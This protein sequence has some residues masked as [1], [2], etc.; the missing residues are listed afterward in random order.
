MALRPV[1][2][3]P[4]GPGAAG[5]RAQRRG[6]HSE[7]RGL[8]ARGH[9]A[10]APFGAMAPFGGS[11]FGGSDP[12]QEFSQGPG[13]GFGGSMMSRFD[14]LAAEMMRGFPDHGEM[15]GFSSNV[16]GG[17]S[18]CQ[19]FAMSSVMGKDGKMHTEKY[20]SSDVGHTG[21]GIREA[22]HAYSNSTSGVDKM[23]L[24]RHLGD[25][26]RKMVKE[27]NRFTMEEKCSEMLRGMDEGGRDH[28]DKD[29]SGLS[30]HLPP[31]GR[32]GALAD[33]GRRGMLPGG[34]QGPAS[35]T[36]GPTG[37]TRGARR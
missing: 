21:H 7:N 19:S 25:R 24:E 10:P 29:F 12:F 33:T 9:E 16:P 17:G 36:S 26:A 37:V 11:L 8:A 5:A 13:F 27:R 32:G 31:H 34:R 20:S 1:D 15:K 18:Y 35:I 3:G 28:F 14:N 2:S 30:R 22:Q 4:G 23:G 6:G